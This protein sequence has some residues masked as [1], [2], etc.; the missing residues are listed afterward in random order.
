[1]KGCDVL[2]A[3]RQLSYS[4]E[5]ESPQ[6]EQYCPRFPFN[7]ADILVLLQWRRPFILRERPL[8]IRLVP[9][10][11]RAALPRLM[12]AARSGA[13]LALR[14]DGIEADRQPGVSWEVHAGPAGFAPSKE[15]FV[16]IFGLFGAGLR[17]R[18]HHY[19]PASFVF[20]LRKVANLDPSR[21][22]LLFV[23]VPGAPRDGGAE[24]FAPVPVSVGEVSIIVDSPMPELKREEQE[25]L[26]REELMG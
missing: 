3:A 19:H 26:R 21:L 5:G 11:Q 22:E 10:E 25:Q 20:P 1:M 4:Y 13:N 18:A 15:S 12:Q 7:L 2:R 17:T 8:R 16:G 14:L 9:P 24:R 23:P 6:V